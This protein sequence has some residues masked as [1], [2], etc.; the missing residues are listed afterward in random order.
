MSTTP[1]S[2]AQPEFDAGPGQ[3]GLALESGLAGGVTAAALAPRAVAE[4]PVAAVQVID[5]TASEL[6]PE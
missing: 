4:E 3:L 6:D 1:I 5:L 2:V